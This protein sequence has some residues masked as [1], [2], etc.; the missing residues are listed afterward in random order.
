MEYSRNCLFKKD[1]EENIIEAIEKGPANDVL[2]QK[3]KIMKCHKR[4]IN[5]KR[6]GSLTESKVAL[7]LCKMTPI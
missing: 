7:Q 3:L 6:D 2:K 5:P 4:A 1:K